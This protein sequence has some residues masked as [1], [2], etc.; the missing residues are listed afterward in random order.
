MHLRG[1]YKQ[2]PSVPQAQA[3]TP[4]ILE[5]FFSN[6][7]ASDLQ[8]PHGSNLELRRLGEALR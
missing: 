5:G 4:K 7:T 2:H 1:L 6:V 3:Q 8:R